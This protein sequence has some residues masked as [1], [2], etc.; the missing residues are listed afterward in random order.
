M[1]AVTSWRS[2]GPGGVAAGCPVAVTLVPL[3][4]GLPVFDG[5]TVRFTAR[6]IVGRQ[7]A[8]EASTTPTGGTWNTSEE[9]TATADS[10]ELAQSVASAPLLFWRYRPVPE[11]PCEPV[12]GFLVAN[13]GQAEEPARPQP[14]PRAQPGDARTISR[15]DEKDPWRIPLLDYACRSWSPVRCRVDHNAAL[16]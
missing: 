14:V 1:P 3:T 16:S 6:T 13:C 11:P 7:Y 5:T 8:L 4:L 12:A 2:S 9:F 10:T 15:F